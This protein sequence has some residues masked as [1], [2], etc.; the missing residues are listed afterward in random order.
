VEAERG[1]ELDGDRAV[2]TRVAHHLVDVS[3][4]QT[5]AGGRVLLSVEPG[6]DEVEI[7]VRCSGPPAALDPLNGSERPT[8]PVQ[9]VPAQR[10]SGLE[11]CRQAVQAHGGSMR[12][13]H[14]PAWPVSYVVRL[15]RLGSGVTAP[16]APAHGTS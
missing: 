16:P 12:I 14:S 11:F 4:R 13:E 7:A 6:L 2:L 10:E 5:S 15:P 1:I 8:L 3:L 9:G